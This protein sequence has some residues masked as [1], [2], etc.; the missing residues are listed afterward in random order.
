MFVLLHHYIKKELNDL[1]KLHI[2]TPII[3]KFEG[4]LQ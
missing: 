2:I 4:D 3:Q 1:E